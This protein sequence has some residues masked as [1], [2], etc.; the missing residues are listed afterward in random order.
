[1]DHNAE[2]DEEGEEEG[3]HSL[4]TFQIRGDKSD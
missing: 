2:E 4:T 1:M 3:G